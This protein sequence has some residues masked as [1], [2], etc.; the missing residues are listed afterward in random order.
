MK[1]DRLLCSQS[2]SLSFIS[3]HLRH[4][5]TPTHSR[6]SKSHTHSHSNKLMHT[7]NFQ[8]TFRQHPQQNTHP[9]ITRHTHTQRIPRSGMRRLS[10]AGDLSCSLHSPKL[11]WNVG[12]WLTGLLKRAK[13]TTVQNIRH[14]SFSFWHT[15]RWAARDRMARDYS[16]ELR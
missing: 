4:T 2:A 16:V 3:I 6:T 5:S 1:T 8:T 13:L 15:K 11:S 9:H 10:Q 7:Q 12:G 14:G